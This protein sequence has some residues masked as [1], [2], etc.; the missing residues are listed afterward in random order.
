MFDGYLLRDILNKIN[1]IHF[2]SSEEID[3]LGL[4]YESMLKE[5]R[6]AAGQKPAKKK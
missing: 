1:H 2:T 4:L 6:D 5:M 3:T